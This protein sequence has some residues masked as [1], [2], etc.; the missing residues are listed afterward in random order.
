MAAIDK[1]RLR[2]LELAVEAT[3]K[4]QFADRKAIVETA[5]MFHRFLTGTPEVD[6]PVA[7]EKQP[8]GKK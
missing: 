5:A 6:G 4:V 8:S 3:S 1:T 7:A 2:A